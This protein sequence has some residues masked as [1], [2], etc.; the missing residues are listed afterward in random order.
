MRRRT[1]LWTLAA[2]PLIGVPLIAQQTPPPESAAPVPV[3]PARETPPPEEVPEPVSREDAEPADERL[4][5][6]NSLSFP[7]DI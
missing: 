6:D 5:V 3:T 4:S 1:W 7:V 2:L